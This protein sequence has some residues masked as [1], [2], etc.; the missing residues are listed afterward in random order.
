MIA[1]NVHI[2]SYQIEGLTD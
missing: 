1:N 2:Q